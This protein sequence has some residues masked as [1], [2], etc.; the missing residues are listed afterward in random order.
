[1][2]IEAGYEIAFECPAQTP[3]LLQLN[4]HP[5]RDAD[6]LT[7]DSINSDPPSGDAL[8]YRSFR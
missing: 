2:L 1:M 7:P 3:M 4:V 5:S 8:L 6:L